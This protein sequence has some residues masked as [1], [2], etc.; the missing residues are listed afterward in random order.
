M[1]KPKNIN[2]LRE[3]LLDAF[4]WVKADP[5]RAGQVQEMSN[6]AGKALSSVKI[7]LEYS[8]ARKEKPEIPFL[9]YK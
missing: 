3:A 9:H 2:E 4:E 7:E 6:A 1:S 8:V 5:R